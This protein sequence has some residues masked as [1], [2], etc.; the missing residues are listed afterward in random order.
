MFHHRVL[1]TGKQKTCLYVTTLRYTRMVSDSNSVQSVQLPNPTK[2]SSDMVG[3]PDPVSN[4]RRIIFRQPQNETTLEK[5][6]REMRSEVQEWNQEFW[7]QHNS[8][9]FQEREEFLK[10]NL[11]E[12]KQNL[13]ADE[14]SVF[15]KA[16]LDKNWNAHMAYNKEW[17]KR[18]VK[19]LAL[20]IQVKIK[21]LLKIKDSK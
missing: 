3:P 5:R 11:P 10:K 13:S 6:Y 17:Y 14:M 21:K 7:S 16:F 8:R 20:S 9:F 12:G 1:L 19:L 15:Y 2:I 18:N 4:L